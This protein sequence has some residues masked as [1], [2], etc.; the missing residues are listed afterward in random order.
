MLSKFR[1]VT[2]TLITALALGHG[3]APAVASSSPCTGNGPDLH[4]QTIALTSG[5]DLSNA[6]LSGATLTMDAT[7]INLRCADL[8][9]VTFRTT[10]PVDGNFANADLTGAD[11][12]HEDFSQ[13]NLA[14]AKVSDLRNVG[15]LPSG[16][17]PAES[18]SQ[19]ETCD[20]TVSIL[21][22][23]VDLSGASISDRYLPENS[24][25]NVD[26]SGTILTGAQICANLPHANLARAD[27]SYAEIGTQCYANSGDTRSFDL[28][29]TNFENAKMYDTI[30]STGTRSEHSNFTGVDLSTCIF[31]NWDAGQYSRALIDTAASNFTRANLSGLDLR[32]AGGLNYEFANLQN[33]NLSG[34]SGGNISFRS[35]NLI[36]ANLS[37]ANLAHANL[38][39]AN[40]SGAV[41]AGSNFQD[42]TLTGIKSQDIEARPD[43][44]DEN[45]S[46]LNGYLVGPSANLSH[47]DLSNAALTNLNLSKARLNYADLSGSDL[48]NANLAGANLNFAN[49][50]SATLQSANLSNAH[51]DYADLD[52]AN[53]SGANLTSSVMFGTNLTNATFAST[54]VPSTL[55]LRGFHSSGT[56]SMAKK[57]SIIIPAANL[58]NANVSNADI[59]KANFS[60][61]NLVGATFYKSNT[62]LA[63]F[64]G[65]IWGN[66]VCA[67]GKTSNQHK[68]STC[69]GTVALTVKA[70]QTR[71]AL[72]AT[73][74]KNGRINLQA[75]TRQNLPITLKVTG[76]CKVSS[77][78]STVASKKVLSYYTLTA[79]PTAGT[80]TLTMAAGSNSYFSGLSQ[81]QIVQITN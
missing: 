57:P 80:C 22:P 28:S 53:L 32:A 61:A 15:K 2:F 65:S 78:Y 4:G 12:G 11:L 74:K 9:G 46:L 77:N 76:G 47:A 16:Y 21:G 40:L 43:N 34:T 23:G 52:S 35:A 66:T 48:T 18:I 69:L 29:D 71:V 70:A 14:G 25:A 42:A 6:N 55:R 62:S 17:I 33:T 49:L 5:K 73:L 3:A 36:N 44:L 1:A 41:L 27:L 58:T 75:V 8:N 81:T 24:Y 67:D 64:I 13:T 51:M 68:G 19:C 79:R 26:L 50:I 60:G 10:A 30:F 7:K 56:K 54:S 38:T 31:Y 20:I 39:N 72:P 37:G 45:W 63:K 59:R